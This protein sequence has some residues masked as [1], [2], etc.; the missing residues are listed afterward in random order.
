[1]HYSARDL[2]L[3]QSSLYRFDYCRE[4]DSAAYNIAPLM[5]NPLHK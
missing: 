1:M 4:F 3:I 5:T 2:T